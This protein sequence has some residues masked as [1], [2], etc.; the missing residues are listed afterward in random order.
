MKLL[1]SSEND[2]QSAVTRRLKQELIDLAGETSRGFAATPDQ[3]SRAKEILNELSRHS[4]IPDPVR[5][6]YSTPKSYDSP[7]PS[8]SLS[9]K[10]TLI[11]TDAPDIIGLGATPNGVAEL[12]R[13]GQECD[14]PFI[15][16]VIEWTKPAW[17][18]DLFNAL[19]VPAAIPALL[20]P[21]V[22]QKVIT[23][24]SASP[25]Q[26]LR[27]RLDVA[28]VQISFDEQ[29]PSNVGDDNR[30]I[31]TRGFLG[32]FL[33]GAVVGRQ[34][35]GFTLPFGEFR[36]LYLDDELRAIR[37]NQGYVAVNVRIRSAQDAWF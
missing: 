27:V 25:D 13:I 20:P 2:V 18:N 3:R 28:G 17:T 26:P 31:G 29:A 16:N 14:P 5:D 9:G 36:V 12:G 11:Y 24:A 34:E 1:V 37:T 35:P 7:S 23:K 21:R 8:P 32:S 15:K 4:P 33:P 30:E 22:L 19:P 6:Y 10:W